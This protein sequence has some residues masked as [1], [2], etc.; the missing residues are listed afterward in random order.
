MA[1]TI[2]LTGATGYIGSHTWIALWE[3]GYEVVGVDDEGDAIHVAVA[4]L[5]FK[6]G[7]RS[8]IIRLSRATNV[9]LIHR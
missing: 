4:S 2:L 9:G 5:Q 6:E 8:V 3:A 1:A 7:F